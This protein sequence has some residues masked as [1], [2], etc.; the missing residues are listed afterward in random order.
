MEEGN[1]NQKVKNHR[2][3]KRTDMN[4]KIPIE[5]GAEQSKNYEVKVND[6]IK[7]LAF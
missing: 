2:G 6:Y 7:Y 5:L 3:K 4:H 1:K